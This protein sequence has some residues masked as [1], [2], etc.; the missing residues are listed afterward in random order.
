MHKVQQA[1]QNQAQDEG[2][3]RFRD[4]IEFCYG[5]SANLRPP[6]C[7]DDGASEQHCKRRRE[8][9]RQQLQMRGPYLRPDDQARDKEDIKA[10]C[11]GQPDSRGHGC[12]SRRSVA[13]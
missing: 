10:Y 3:L 6:D 5:V 2:N 1:L 11:R 4:K 7:V 13:R 8:Q 9:K 12:T